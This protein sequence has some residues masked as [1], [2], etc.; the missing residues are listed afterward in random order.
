MSGMDPAVGF[1][2]AWLAAALALALH[3]ADEASHDFLA[4]YNPRAVR[5]RRAL[6]GLPFPPTFTFVPWLL[7]LIAAVGLLVALTP[8]AWAARP[9]MRAPATFVATIHVG[10]GLL[11][12]IGSAVERRPVP[13]VLSAPMLLLTGSWLLY[14]TARLP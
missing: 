7:S 4:W 8:M 14:A 11:H 12:L 9:W 6:G 1:G 2:W 3:V 13:G 5:I 10:N